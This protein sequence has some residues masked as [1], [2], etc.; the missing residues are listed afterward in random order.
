MSHLV[1]FQRVV[2]LKQLATGLL[3]VTGKNLL[4]KC[5]DFFWFVL[6][7]FIGEVLSSSLSAGSVVLQIC[8]RMVWRM[9][10]SCI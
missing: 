2:F 9:M 3:L 8:M 1:S 10:C 6:G 5:D 4:H 7:D